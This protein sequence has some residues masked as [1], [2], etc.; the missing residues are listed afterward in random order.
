MIM[1]KFVIKGLMCIVSSL[2]N[3]LKLRCYTLDSLF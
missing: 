3:L 1:V 2:N